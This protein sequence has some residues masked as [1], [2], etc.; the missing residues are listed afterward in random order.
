MREREQVLVRGRALVRGLEL[1][2]VRVQGPA[3]E[4]AQVR[5]SAPVWGL[6]QE[7]VRGQVLVPGRARGPE[8]AQVLLAL[9]PPWWCRSRRR[10]I[11]RLHRHHNP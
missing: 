7:Q 5:V 1:V 11:H 2:Q 4:P 8:R 3:W 9:R 10:S 6:A